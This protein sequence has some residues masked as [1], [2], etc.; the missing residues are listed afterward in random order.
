MNS[1]STQARPAAGE[2]W[3]W[4]LEPRTDV[5]PSPAVP[6]AAL[7]DRIAIVGTAGS[8]KTYAAKGVVERLLDSGARVNDCRSL[9]GLGGDCAPAPMLP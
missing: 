9:G 1:M 4:P 2:R 3:S 7:D 6:A 5:I 8:G